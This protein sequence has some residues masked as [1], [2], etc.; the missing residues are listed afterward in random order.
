MAVVHNTLL[1]RTLL[2]I[3]FDRVYNTMFRIMYYV[4]SLVVA[5]R[6]ETFQMYSSTKITS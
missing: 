1:K 2:K 4:R 5:N 3:S 6:L